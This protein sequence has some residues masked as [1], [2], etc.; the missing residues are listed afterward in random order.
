ME[1]S[2]LSDSL[3]GIVAHLVYFGIAAVAAVVFVAAYVAVTPHHEL[4]LIRQG[5]T[6]AA[7]SLGG[8]ILGYTVP[9]SKAVA[10]SESIADML[11]WSAVALVAQLLAYGVARLTL[12]RLSSDVDEGRLASGVFLAAI[13]LAI[14]LLN[15]AAM[16]E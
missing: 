12:P 8:A 7:V 1:T 14:G 9:L 6:A 13:S 3:T 2:L 5:N 16:T 4:R 15:A 10:Q 11:L